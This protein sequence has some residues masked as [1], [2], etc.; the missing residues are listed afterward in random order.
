MKRALVLVTVASAA[1]LAVPA[2]AVPR[3]GNLGGVRCFN[4]AR[5]CTVWIA[6]TDTCR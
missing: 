5:T 1:L 2:H 3:C 4:G 6:A